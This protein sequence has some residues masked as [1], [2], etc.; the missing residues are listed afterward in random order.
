MCDH[1]VYVNGFCVKCG[2]WKVKPRLAVAFD[3]DDTLI[4][5]E[6]NG[7]AVPKYFVIDL[8]RWFLA[9]ADTKVIMWSGG[10]VDYARR[11]AERLGVANDV[12]V[13][14]KGSVPVDIAVDDMAHAEYER[15]L[16]KD[17]VKVVIAV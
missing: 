11:W 12:I 3:V 13:V 17:K 4:R 5:W 15:Q 10:G 9:A 16:F 7:E 8:M 14:E 1:K 6:K 2:D